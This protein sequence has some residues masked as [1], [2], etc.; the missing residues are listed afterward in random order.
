MRVVRI[1]WLPFRVPYV[2]PFS[3]AHGSEQ[4]RCGAIIRATTDDGRVGLGEAAPLPAFGGGTLDDTL[5]QIAKRGGAALVQDPKTAEIPIMPV[6]AIKAVPRAET[7]PLDAIAP[8][9]IALSQVRAKVGARK[10]V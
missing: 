10:V 5:A 6:A 2:V 1:A 8:R 9:L 7:L 4:E 3:T